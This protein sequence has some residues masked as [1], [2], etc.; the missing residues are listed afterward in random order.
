ME[1]LFTTIYRVVMVL[2]CISVLG[3]L[4]FYA[5]S[6]LFGLLAITL[7]LLMGILI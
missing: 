3:V 1:D 5:V 2:V 6:G 7:E 4:A